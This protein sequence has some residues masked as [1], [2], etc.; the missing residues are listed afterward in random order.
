MEVWLLLEDIV[1]LVLLDAKRSAGLLVDNSGESSA[2][3][4]LRLLLRGLLAS[5]GLKQ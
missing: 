4:S 2:L 5:R 1:R 3:G